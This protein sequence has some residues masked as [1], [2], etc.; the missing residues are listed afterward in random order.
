MQLCVK[1]S[2]LAIR[3]LLIPRDICLFH[4]VHCV[5]S[6]PQQK[7]KILDTSVPVITS[8]LSSIIIHSTNVGFRSEV[9]QLMAV[10]KFYLKNK[11]FVAM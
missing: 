10:G 7:Q 11:F 8:A 4:F 6:V 2:R 9:F 3:Y 1:L 5:F